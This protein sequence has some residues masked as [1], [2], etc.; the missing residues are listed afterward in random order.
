MLVDT[1]VERRHDTV[2]RANKTREIRSSEQAASRIQPS[3][4]AFTKVMFLAGGKGK[5]REAAQD[6]ALSIAKQSQAP[7]VP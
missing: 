1:L 3:P 6:H 5:H 2:G 7:R 4:N